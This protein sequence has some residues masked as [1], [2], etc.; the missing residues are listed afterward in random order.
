MKV[1]AALQSVHVALECGLNF[2]DTPPQPVAPLPRARAS[3]IYA[4]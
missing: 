4:P 2:I 3:R 1:E